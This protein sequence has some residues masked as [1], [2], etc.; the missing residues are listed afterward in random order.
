ML[1]RLKVIAFMAAIIFLSACG[2]GGGSS[3][4]GGV[5][6]PPSGGG[7]ETTSLQVS[8]TSVSFES[9]QY[10]PLPGSQDISVTASGSNVAQVIAGFAPGVTPPDWLGVAI[11]GT[12]A[13]ST[14]T[15]SIV[16]NDIPFRTYTTPL[17]VVSAT[18]ADEVIDTID[19]NITFD[20]EEGKLLRV[21]RGEITVSSTPR[22]RPVTETVTLSASGLRTGEVINWERLNSGVVGEDRV[23]FD[24]SSG[25]LAP[26]ETQI[27]DLMIES[28][29]S[30]TAST[31]FIPV[32][33]AVDDDAKGAALQIRAN[34]ID[35]LFSEPQDVNVVFE[36]DETAA[37]STSVLLRNAGNQEATTATWQSS[38]E[39][40]WI[41]LGRT[42]SSTLDI[43]ID[44]ST[45]SSGRNEGLISVTHDISEQVL[46]IPVFAIISD[47]TLE[48]SQK[49]VALSNL[50][51]LSRQI[52]ITDNDN[53]PVS[54]SAMVT[55]SWLTVTASG[56]AG[57]PLVITADTSGLATDSL[58]TA[59][60]IV[61]N[62]SFPN[63]VI[64]KVGLWVGG[65]VE[66]RVSTNIILTENFG[67][68]R[69][70]ESIVSDPIRPYI[71]VKT[72]APNAVRSTEFS[73]YNVFTGAKV[74]ETLFVDIDPN[75][76]LLISDDGSYAF[77][78]G[79]DLT[80]NDD[81]SFAKVNL[82]DMGID[83][84]RLSEGI[85]FSDV[86]F[87]RLKSQGLLITSRGLVI[88]V[89]TETVVSD[90]S[91]D[92]GTSNIRVSPNGK[93]SCLAYEGNMDGEFDCVSLSGSGLIGGPVS[94]EPLGPS[95]IEGGSFRLGAIFE[96]SRM[97]ENLIFRKDTGFG[98]ELHSVR[99]EDQNQN[100]TLN[101]SQTDFHLDGQDN[102][103]VATGDGVN[104]LKSEIYNP[105]GMLIAS[106]S[107]E[108]SDRSDFAEAIFLSGDERRVIQL[109]DGELFFMPRPTD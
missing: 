92:F 51:D 19:M 59:D 12:V 5:T 94:G 13:S 24:P 48:V 65:T 28:Q 17:R 38:T 56:D 107:F 77:I 83:I 108:T 93:V 75:G 105:G 6:P 25:T 71:Y 10:Q 45:L 62:P 69:D 8:T 64:V 109:L 49:G 91:R 9:R 66:T 1:N 74:G 32:E 76:D 78:A 26:G 70:K 23:T 106:D 34:S 102:I 80:G 14:L 81:R 63:D 103:I 72:E 97:G 7:G 29:G 11:E 53:V 33:F 31:S 87:T 67:L 68:A 57:D 82:D 99:I 39:Q 100:F 58:Q 89:E 22:S 60:V 37:K 27:L 30:G 50:S 101:L 40:S 79:A 46:E 55:E 54:W 104:R 36:D 96:L 21:D 90:L 95:N 3:S 73:T 4:G 16:T 98:D 15:L 47:P 41:T 20:L 88:D 2:G 18:A 43:T 35:G 42:G 86:V 61:S 85:A 44:P 84:I 52:N